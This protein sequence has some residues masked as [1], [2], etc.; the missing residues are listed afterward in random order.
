MGRPPVRPLLSSIAAFVTAS[1]IFVAPA[2]AQQQPETGLSPAGEAVGAMV[3]TLLIGGCLILFAPKYTERTTQRI[4]DE[5]GRTFLIG[6]GLSVL[7]IIALFF[8]IITVIGILVAIPLIILLLIV[9]E[10]GYLAVGRLVSDS[11]GIVLLIAMVPAAI[12]GGVPILGGILG[13]VL[14]CFGLGTAYLEYKD[15]GN[16]RGSA[17]G[18]HTGGTGDSWSPPPQ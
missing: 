16:S 5:P 2:T 6:V 1:L 7:L 11:W 9:S 10:L 17:A 8:L 14:S 13:F 12:V 18:A 4:H 15:D 3:L